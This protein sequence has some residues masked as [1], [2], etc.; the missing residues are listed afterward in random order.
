MR[1][2]GRENA[3]LL[4]R[5][6]TNARFAWNDFYPTT[7]EYQVLW[8]APG[9]SAIR[10]PYALEQLRPIEQEYEIPLE[11]GRGEPALHRY[12]K[13]I[14]NRFGDARAMAERG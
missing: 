11:L 14:V 13:P 4:L 9:T 8:M 2:I 5:H 1:F 6:G 10:L 3:I 7:S 12:S